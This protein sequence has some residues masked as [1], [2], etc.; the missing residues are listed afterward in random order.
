MRWARSSID[1]ATVSSGSLRRPRT[2]KSTITTHDAALQMCMT[3]S[4]APNPRPG[5]DKEIPTATSPILF[6]R[7]TSPPSRSCLRLP[8][9]WALRRVLSK[10]SGALPSFS[11]HSHFTTRLHQSSAHLAAW[12]RKPTVTAAFYYRSRPKKLG[13]I[14]HCARC[15]KLVLRFLHLPFPPV[16]HRFRISTRYTRRHHSIQRVSRNPTSLDGRIDQPPS[17]PAFARSPQ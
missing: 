11:F 17:H 16:H 9:T 5:R 6:H 1:T 15:K 3:N 7:Q 4:R 2:Q 10:P 8:G 13:K 14:S 12:Q